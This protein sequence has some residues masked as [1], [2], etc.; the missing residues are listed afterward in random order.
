VRIVCLHSFTAVGAVGL[1]PYLEVL[2]KACLPVPTVVLT[3]PGNLP[4]V[5]RQ[6]LDAASLLD[7]VLSH[8]GGAGERVVVL[9]GYLAS[10]AQVEPLRRVV[11]AHRGA[12]DALV[13]DPICGDDGR[14]YVAE[15]LV[16]AWSGLLV[17]ADWALPNATEVELLAG[18]KGVR[19]VEA[20]R[21]RWPRPGLIVT[22]V[23]EG[24]E[25]VTRLRA[26]SVSAEH[27]QARLAG[28]GSG[29]GDLFGAWWVRRRWLEGD[30]PAEAMAE[31]A[32]RVAIAIAGSPS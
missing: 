17:A 32:R 16:A 20:F 9:I 7:G 27:R 29:T 15:E 24:S 13:I 21:R 6:A 19:S 5:R 11:E 12:V 8:L 4:G 2:G 28:G 14:A 25:V 22:G 1:R 31:A 30:G 23:T 26:G 3:G 18:V 10:G